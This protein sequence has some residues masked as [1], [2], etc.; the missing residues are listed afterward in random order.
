MRRRRP[1]PAALLIAVAAAG[2]TLA[3]AQGD[4]APELTWTVKP[5]RA[6]IGDRVAVDM[7]IVVPA[8]LAVGMPLFPTWSET[9]GETEILDVEEP[10][11]EPASAGATRFRQTIVLTP[12][13]TGELA[14]P[15]PVVEI[16]TAARILKISASKPI[17]VTIGSVLPEGDERPAPKPPAP[18]QPLP[19]SEIF[20]WTLG[21]AGAACLLA[22]ALMVLR[23]RAA[24]AAARPIVVDPLTAFRDT[25]A[26]LEA[27]DDPLPLIAGLS[28]ALRRYLGGRL[29]FGAAES[30]TT[31]IRRRLQDRELPAGLVI[32]ID[33]LLKHCDAIKFARRPIEREAC[34]EPLSEA[35][36]IADTLENLLAPPPAEKSLAETD[37]EAA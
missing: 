5:V 25:L 14:L 32:G 2:A 35:A 16:P 36:R 30:T 18:P 26:A 15:S 1:L 27:S 7:E 31:E 17:V 13:K 11:A 29:G 8:G 10:V 3:T 21:I 23:G 4:A 20:W 9:W 33:R 12:W 34:A 37:R 28:L 24:I 19:V 22:T 6:E